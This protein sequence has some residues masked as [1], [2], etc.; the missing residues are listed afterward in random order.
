MTQ[1]PRCRAS[2]SIPCAQSGIDKGLAASMAPLQQSP[3]NSSGLPQA[4]GHGYPLLLSN[5]QQISR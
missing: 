2:A 1:M 5:Y 4:E 3:L